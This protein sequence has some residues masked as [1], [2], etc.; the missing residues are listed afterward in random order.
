ML[1]GPARGDVYDLVAVAAPSHVPGW[2]TPDVALPELAVTALDLACPAGVEP[3][4]YEGLRER[5]LPE[6]TFRGRV[7]HRNSRVDLRLCVERV[8]GSNPHGQLGRCVELRR[9][10]RR[11]RRSSASQCRWTPDGRALRP[12]LRRARL[13]T[14]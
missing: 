12:R 1:S 4:E 14:G 11:S 5:Y 2:F 10:Q 9:R 8:T 7:E 6:V 13:V 3:L